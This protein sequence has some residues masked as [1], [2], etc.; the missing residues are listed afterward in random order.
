MTF[1]EAAIEIL[2][3]AEAPLHFAE[4]AK[5]AVDKN[6]LSHVG[7]DPEA[8]MRSCLNSASRIGRDG[9]APIIVRDKPGCYALRPGAVLPPP[10]TPAEPEVATVRMSRIWTPSRK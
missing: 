1:L 9:D 6:L 4:V 5:R 7:R 3:T 8:A 2:R 10:S